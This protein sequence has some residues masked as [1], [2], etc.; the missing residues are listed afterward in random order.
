LRLGKLPPDLLDKHI[1]KMTGASSVDL[2]VPPAIGLDFGVVRLGKSHLIVSS[3]PVTGVEEDIG[4]FAVNVS[5]NDVATSGNRPRFMQSVI[6][7]PDRAT[8]GQ[9]RKIGTQMDRV[10]K[11][12]GITLVGGHTELTPGLERPIVIT[13]AFAV[14]DTYV[15][16]ANA[17]KDDTIL[18][19][20]SAGLEGTA[21]LLAEYRTA[22]GGNHKAKRLARRFSQQMSI[23]D[24]AETGFKTG[25]V[26]AM[27][28]CTEGGVLGAVYEMAYASGLGFEVDAAQIPVDEETKRLCRELK[29][30]PLKLISSGALLLAV[31][32]GKD[33]RVQRALRSIGTPISAIGRFTSRK[34]M[35]LLRGSTREEIVGG[36]TDELW[37][38]KAHGPVRKG[39]TSHQ[40]SG[41]SHIS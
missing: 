3:D 1:L 19:T 32:P 25:Y 31:V 34:K 38:M 13:T 18:L 23:V 29:I 28:D 41:D 24:E 39:T 4:E 35:I 27:H 40:S 36:V 20:K 8:V 26:N 37:R 21:I 11:R 30:D 12:L 5:A 2:V 15:S 6:L 7:L 9:L 22:A 10:A 14:G 16:A 17:K 33:A